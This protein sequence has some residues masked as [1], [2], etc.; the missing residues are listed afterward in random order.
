MHDDCGVHLTSEAIIPWQ[1]AITSSLYVLQM[2]IEILLLAHPPFV[3][4]LAN[5]IIILKRIK[6][7]EVQ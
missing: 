1:K 2:L 7:K 4:P 6:K 5:P 3:L